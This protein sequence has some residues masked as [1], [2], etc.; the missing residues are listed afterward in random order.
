[1]TPTP[2]SKALKSISDLKPDPKNPRRIDEDSARALSKS[3]Y[4]FGD[5]SGIVWNEAT[6]ELV[7][8]HQRV[9]QLKRAG[10]GLCVGTDP[11]LESDGRRFP[12]RVVNW[13]PE[14]Q[15]AANIAA[16]NQA[17]AGVFTDDVSELLEQVKEDFGDEFFEALRFD[18][19]AIPRPT[20]VEDL[21]EDE[22]PEPKTTRVEPGDVW[23]LGPHRLVCGDSADPNTYDLFEEPARVSVTDPPYDVGLGEWV[24]SP[25]ENPCGG[26]AEH[27][28]E[29]N[30]T[31]VAATGINLDFL[32]ILPSDV[33]VMT[34]PVDAHFFE[35]ADA[36]KTAGFVLKR[37]LIWV[38]DIAPF[39][40]RSTYQQRHEPILVC[41]KK[42]RPLGAN[43]TSKSTTVLEYPKPKRHES[44]PTA[45]PVALFGELIQNHTKKGERV[46]D[47]FLGSGTTLIA[48][49]QLGRK[50]YGIEREPAF[51]DVI[52]ERW[53]KLTGRQAVLEGK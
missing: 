6:G 28:F 29:K 39:S 5:L 14:K 52:L 36:M 7:A 20:E 1:M 8:G 19:V 4:E 24:R 13:T 18:A 22:P 15:R 33:L 34:Y 9:D 53:E 47:P 2:K 26:V 41:H 21:E 25:H 11:V 50:C 23:Q 46:L 35:L 51:C 48:A 43:T 38:K 12:V 3:M 44:H 10:A 49:E 27:Y 42:G 31:E 45:K 30:R 16:N 32:S 37:E 40:Y 17:I